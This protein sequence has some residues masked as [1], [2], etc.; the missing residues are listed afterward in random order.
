M[1]TSQDPKIQPN[2]AFEVLANIGETAK[3]GDDGTRVYVL[4]CRDTVE[5]KAWMEAICSVSGRLQLSMVRHHRLSYY[6]F[7]LSSASSSLVVIVG[8]FLIVR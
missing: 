8:G 5:A 4:E 6:S 2:V 1:K 7:L 3:A